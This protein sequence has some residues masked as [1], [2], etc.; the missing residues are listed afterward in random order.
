VKHVD[1]NGNALQ[2][3][4]TVVLIKSLNVKGANFMAKRG[5]T[6][7]RISLVADNPEHIEGRVDG[8]HIVILTKFIKKSK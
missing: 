5:T 1:S 2:N 7:R 8:Q 4:D 3:G 6:V